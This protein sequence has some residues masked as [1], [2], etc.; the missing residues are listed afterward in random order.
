[1]KKNLLF[2]SLIAGLLIGMTAFTSC[3]KDDDNQQQGDAPV[4][5]AEIRL[6]QTE[7]TMTVGDEDVELTAI[8]APGNAAITSVDW[9][10]SDV[11]VATVS[12][13]GEV[14]AV[15]DGT[16]IITAKAMDGSGVKATCTVTV[17]AASVRWSSS[18]YNEGV[19]NGTIQAVDFTKK[20]AS[21][22]IELDN[23]STPDTNWSG[24]YTVIGDD[25]K[26]NGNITLTDD[27]YLILCD[28][29]K[30]TISG[31]INGGNHKLY[32][33]GQ[34]ANTG[35]LV[36]ACPGGMQGVYHLSGWQIHGGDIAISDGAFPPINSPFDLYGGKLTVEQTVG[37]GAIEVDKGI[38]IYG[39]D[40]IAK[41]NPN[42][43]YGNAISVGGNNLL[44]YGGKVKA[45]GASSQYGSGIIGHVWMTG[46][47][48][49]AYGGDGFYNNNVGSAGIMGNLNTNGTGSTPT[50][51]TVKGGKGA[52]GK[53]GGYGVSG[54]VEVQ[55]F[56]DVTIT[57]GNGGNTGGNGA[58][59]IGGVLKTNSDLRPCT[60]TIKVYGGTDSSGA[61]GCGIGGAGND[62][63]IFYAGGNIEVKSGGTTSAIQQTSP[64]MGDGKIYASSANLTY[65]TWGG[66]D[67]E[68]SGT[69]VDKPNYSDYISSPGVK[70]VPRQ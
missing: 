14:H 28:G 46:G 35:K 7:L 27:T 53:D 39:G 60:S 54:N 10:S 13:L 32:I 24:W 26:I 48:L 66:T 64:T 40:L 45:Y 63:G 70:I 3:S 8:V 2:L 11:S 22:L 55:G 33:Y 17:N 16:A 62:H 68:T 21:W 18:E 43:P 1:M 59:G 49:E 6:D 52:A 69:D 15:A 57:G 61:G 65:Y 36:V 25:V 50:K 19:W 51:V 37:G 44:I 41:V 34:E 4:K 67:W 47:E 20:T 9:S 30:L 5:V 23:T 29:A 58:S 42:A 31:Y 56:C 38:S 12:S